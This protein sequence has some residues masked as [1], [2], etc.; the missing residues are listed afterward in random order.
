M[1]FDLKLQQYVEW[2]V[3]N[4]T[5]IKDGYGYRVILSYIDGTE[6]VQQKSGFKTKREASADRDKTLGQLYSDT[7]VVYT[8]VKVKE[9]LEF[10]LEED[11]RPRVTNATYETYRSAVKN[12]IIPVIGNMLMCD[13]S[14]SN[15]IRL[16]K[17]KILYSKSVVKNIKVILNTAL[18]FALTRKII[19]INPAE[20]IVLPKGF[21]TTNKAGYHTRNIDSEKTLSIDQIITLIEASKETP[22]YLQ[23]LFAVLMGLRRSEIIGVKYSDIDYVHQTLHVQRQLGFRPYGEKD[24]NLKVRPSKQEIKLKTLSSD[25]II[26]I[27]DY[28][29]QAI[30]EQRKTYEKNRRRRKREFLDLDYIC[31]STY[32]NP[33]SKDF[34][35]KYY[36]K[37]LK[38][39]NLPDIRWHDLRSTFCTLLL[40][41]DFNPKAV[42]KLMGHSKEVITVDVY[43]DTSRII[44]DCLKEL[45]PFIDE[46]LSDVDSKSTEYSEEETFDTTKEIESFIEECLK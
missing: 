1:K 33:R 39:N 31:C 38:E 42:S 19:S 43:G 26:P 4:V 37:L 22:I 14:K 21:E 32:G 40:K 18:K 30:L 27:P 34:H 16:Y 2:K 13:L 15:V 44:Q 29:M 8:N 10:W 25:R 17:G 3:K 45:E 36:K 6:I 9:Y 41:N 11:I 5:A 7:Y 20:N 46:M 28:V 24:E 35:F 23:V 12:H